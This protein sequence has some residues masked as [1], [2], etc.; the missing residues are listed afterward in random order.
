[1]I[2]TYSIEVLLRVKYCGICGS[3]MHIYEDGHI[4]SMKV[5]T[6]KPFILGH[7]SS[8]TVLKVGSEVKHLQVGD[9]VTI[10]PSIPCR[11]CDFCL[12]GSYNLCSESNKYSRGLPSNNGCM[13]R[14]F[15]HPANFC[16]KIPENISFEEGALVEP[17]SCALFGVQ[18]TGLKAG[19]KVLIVGAGPI[20]L[21]SLLC[22]KAF[23]ADKTCVIG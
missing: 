15:V 21:L 19:D 5:E 20:G 1:M 10:E 16:F 8:A 9:R 6:G 17:L 13:Q 18:R 12:Q 23:G 4:G 22:A 3:D 11:N 14:Y 2:L 7:E